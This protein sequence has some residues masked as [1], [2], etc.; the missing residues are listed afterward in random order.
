MDDDTD[1]NKYAIAVFFQDLKTS[2]ETIDMHMYILL[3]KLK[4]YGFK[5]FYYLSN[6]NK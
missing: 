2:S 6:I 4:Y 3:Q 1:N 5:W